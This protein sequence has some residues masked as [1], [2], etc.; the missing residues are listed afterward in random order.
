[1]AV[2]FQSLDDPDLAGSLVGRTQDAST[3]NFVLDFGEDGAYVAFD[4]NDD[5]F[6]GLMDTSRPDSLNARW[7]NV[8]YPQR[9]KQMI[10]TLARIYDF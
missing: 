10:E 9:Q 6:E 7:I 1:M 3:S 4:V 8:W 5:V 2:N